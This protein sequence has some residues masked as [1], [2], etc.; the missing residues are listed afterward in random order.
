MMM[1]FDF[2]LS[3]TYIL[4]PFEDHQVGAAVGYTVT[5]PCRDWEPKCLGNSFVLP[6]CLERWKISRLPLCTSQMDGEIASGRTSPPSFKNVPK[7]VHLYFDIL[8]GAPWNSPSGV[9]FALVFG[10]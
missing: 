10:D 4:A 9:D 2:L 1:S 7:G 3:L 6:T 8:W 5:S